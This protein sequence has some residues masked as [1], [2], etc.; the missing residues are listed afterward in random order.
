MNFIRESKMIYQIIT[1]YI[2]LFIA[3][4]IIV[5][6]SK[7]FL[8]KHALNHFDNVN[9]ASFLTDDVI[10][11]QNELKYKTDTK[12]NNNMIATLDEQL[13]FMEIYTKELLM[14]NILIKG[15][16]ENLD[17]EDLEKYEDELG[18]SFKTT[19]SIK[20]LVNEDI[21]ASDNYN[22]KNLIPFYYHFVPVIFQNFNSVGFNIVNYYFIGN[23]NNCN[24][25]DGE[26]K[27]NNLYFKYPLE[28][29]NLGIDFKALN[30]KIYDYIIDPFIDCNNGYEFD[31]KLLEFIKENNWYYNMIREEEDK[32]S[33]I[34]FR[35]LKLIKIN[36]QN[37]RKDFYIAYNKFNLIYN[38]ESN[39]KINFLLAIRLSKDKTIYPFILLNENNDTLNYDYY[40]IFN[41]DKKDN[42]LDLDN[43]R[44]E[45]NFIY[46]YD[47]NIDDSNN[48]ILR[49]PKFIE[50]I[51]YF[52]MQKKEVSSQMRSLKTNNNIKL[53]T[54]N[55]IL[56][57]YKEMND[58]ESYYD[59][60]YYLD[61]DILF[62]KLFYFLNQFIL[63]KKKYPM[64]LI[65]PVEIKDD[66]IHPCSVIDIDEYYNHIKEKFDY[67]CIYDYCFFHNCDF[68]NDLF[69]NINEYLSPNCYC[70]PLYCK[71]EKTQKNTYFEK[72]LR[73]KLGIDD[74]EE[75]DYSF[76]SNYNYY[77]SEFE[78]QFSK[79]NSYFNRGSFDFRCQ[80]NFGKKNLEKNNTYMAFIFFRNY[81]GHNDFNTLIIF[82]YNIGKIRDIVS[83]LNDYNSN[84][85]A[86]VLYGYLAI[87][88]ALG[89]LLL[90]YIYISCNKLINKMNK[91]KNIR[92]VIITNA[93]NTN[94]KNINYTVNKNVN[95]S[96]NNI[97]DSNSLNKLLKDKINEDNIN[98][99]NN[100]NDN[101]I[102]V[103][104]KKDL[105]KEDNSNSNENKDELDELIQLINDN[106]STFKI[107]FNLNEELND[108]VNNIKKQYNEIIQVN[109][110]KNKLLLKEDK[111]E[112]IFDNPNDNSI[113]SS[114]NSITG[115]KNDKV[116]DLSVNIFCELLSLSNHKFDF[117]DIKT[118]FYYRESNDNALYNLNKI[119]A[120]LNETGTSNENVEIANIDK[121]NNALEHYSNNIH[122]Y[123]KNYYDVQKAKDE[124]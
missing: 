122:S 68:L 50:N 38:E 64:Y 91:V 118:N 85:I 29:N 102:N 92:K 16:F 115:K 61:A 45:P 34:H 25:D 13:L 93:N 52:G 51:N 57:K 111:E 75:F 59:I 60:N 36:Q 66:E 78:A 43:L 113:I 107:E 72:S 110:Y 103:Q 53:T 100:E 82:I 8:I 117:S 96:E 90:I 106:L 48:I 112:I 47:Y 69:I 22:I 41:F 95:K 123:W 21:E 30:N 15:I 31:E 119:I 116:D 42:H 89:I 20:N 71:D 40:S 65:S 94:S 56:V 33:E 24:V 37:V 6:S 28:A 63:F 55:S 5:I 18:E 46:N 88:F 86:K 44:K 105:K 14:H 1:I 54:D 2:I 77:M 99:L 7:Q 98:E 9:Y 120:T 101:L 26:E 67:D 124:I 84:Y 23:D 62:Y 17:K 74:D 49:N 35:F 39:K 70:L 121:L 104:E 114:N 12:N 108:N 81:Y 80:L 10:K 3:F 87:F 109:K 27:I 4:L 83:E 32:N 76:N 79:V 11:I 19:L 97:N 58:I 73:E